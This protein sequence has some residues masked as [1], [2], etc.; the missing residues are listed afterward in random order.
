M[1]RQM[2]RRVVTWYTDSNVDLNYG[3]RHIVILYTMF[4]CYLGH[5][6]LLTFFN[7]I[8][9]ITGHA[10]RHIEEGDEDKVDYCGQ[11]MM[12]IRT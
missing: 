10:K 2:T 5:S 11:L 8:T 1:D 7:S 12:G 4:L 3:V 6:Q 9:Q